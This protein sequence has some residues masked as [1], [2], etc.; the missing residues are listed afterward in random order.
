[1]VPHNCITKMDSFNWL[2]FGNKSLFYL[3]IC[4]VNWTRYRTSFR[5]DY[6][7]SCIEGDINIS[8]LDMV[9][10]VIQTNLHPAKNSDPCVLSFAHF[11]SC[12]ALTVWRYASSK[13]WYPATF[14]RKYTSFGSPLTKACLVFQSIVSWTSWDMM[15]T[16][17]FPPSIIASLRFLTRSI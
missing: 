3:R 5:H 4:N 11:N 13:E 6:L 15:P 14:T 7:F 10:L 16:R 9:F 1:M 17:I 12:V 8:P 2:N